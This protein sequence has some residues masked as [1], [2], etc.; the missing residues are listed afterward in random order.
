MNGCEEIRDLIPWYVEGTLSS[1]DGTAVASH[2]ASCPDCLR[3]V[4]VAIRLRTAVR[5]ALSSEPRVSEAMWER[6]ARQA[7]GRRLAQLDVGSFIVG[8]RLGAWLTRRGSPVRADLRVLGHDVH[9]VER[10]SGG[11]SS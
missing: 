4:A 2:L 10:K 7:L 6:V 3:D 8:F 9:L 5:D 1:E 11:R